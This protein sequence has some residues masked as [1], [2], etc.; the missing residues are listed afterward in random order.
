ML[1]I[2]FG[3]G[4]SRAKSRN[5]KQS[6]RPANLARHNPPLNIE[7]GPNRFFHQR[8][9][10]RWLTALTILLGSAAVLIFG[11]GEAIVGVRLADVPVLQR[12]IEP[13]DHVLSDPAQNPD[14]VINMRVEQIDGSS[15][16]TRLFT[17]VIV[18]L[19][20]TLSHAQAA[21]S[22]DENTRESQ[23]VPSS[24]PVS[25][26]PQEIMFGASKPEP[27]P[28]HMRAFAPVAD[29]IEIS[30][31]PSLGEAV[32]LTVVPKT[33]VP[34]SQTRRII[35]ARGGDTLDRIFDVLGVGAEDH[36]AL[37][38]LL[39]IRSRFRRTAFAG[40]E[41]IT[42]VFGEDRASSRP[43]RVGVKR[44]GR[45]ELAAALNDDGRYVPVTPHAEDRRP[46]RVEGEV[47]VAW[48]LRRPSNMLL[49]N[50]LFG[51]VGSALIGLPMV[52][53]LIEICAHDFN[54][55]AQTAADDSVEILY[56][57]DSTGHPELVFAALKAQGHTRLYYRFRTLDDD[58]VDYYDENGRSLIR[59]FLR[60]PVAAAR[61]GDGFGWRVHPIL[62]E[63]R[64]HDGVDY[65]A[66][67]GSPIVSA[68]AGIVEKIDQQWG[69]G[70]YIRIRHDFGYETTYAH[71]SSTAE[72][73]HVGDRV[74]QGQT[75]AY[76]GSTGLSTGPHL[77]YELRVNKR[78]V[79]PL[80]SQPSSGRVLVGTV[81]SEF[82]K[83]RDRIDL[84][85]KASVAKD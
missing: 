80:R 17:H 1:D 31:D 85:R 83:E 44:E 55:V 27:L 12:T 41:R 64:F 38:A 66:P 26:L 79:D 50:S 62:G 28:S 4:P 34:K 18:P 24:L 52:E 63:R 57:S 10:L 2:G 53:E 77:Y 16:G 42:V 37:A 43:L 71:I 7:L 40:G 81:L 68:G 20:G 3:H 5:S 47:N 49:R 8:E 58:S 54:L 65:A 60:K 11:A 33:T 48:D 67:L 72:N 23:P 84:L 22:G 19:E 21:E 75:I 59:S 70:K 51:M 45:P 78:D 61:L 6:A 36:R 39:T 76:V 32:N 29:D 9:S 13:T 25:L 15:I 56:S 73:L 82:Q 74:R 35:V 46:P 14:E 69:Y 30:S